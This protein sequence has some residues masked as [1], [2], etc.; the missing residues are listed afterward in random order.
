MICPYCQNDTSKVLDSRDAGS[1]IRRRRQC[2]DC[3]RRFT[4]H[5]RVEQRLPQVVKKNGERQP[6]NRDKV[7]GGFA[8]A[9]RKRP[10]TPE[11]LE[12][13]TDRV[14]LRCLS[15][16][17]REIASSRVGQLVL[18][19]LL[20]LDRVGYLRFASV[21]QEFASV[22]EFQRMLEPLLRERN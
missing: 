7:L 10:A 2:E 14:V 11:D 3:G 16:G 5:E 8:L 19:D 22:E 1:S 6:F 17:D 15:E 12:S 9:C 21:Y 20:D 18:E 13:A 4:T